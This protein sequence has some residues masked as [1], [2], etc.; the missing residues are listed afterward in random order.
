MHRHLC[1]V[2]SAFVI[3]S[4]AFSAAAE[5]RQ[6]DF[7]ETYLDNGL[8]VLT[9][10]DFST[11]IVAV[12]V[13]YHV[14]SKN[15]Q[16]DRQGFAH[17]FEHMMFRGS[18]LVPPEAHAALIRSVGGD[19]NAFTSFDF[20]GYVNTMPSNQL[21]LAL[22]LEAERMLFLTVDQEGFDTERQVVKEERRQDLNQPYGTVFER[23][24]PVIF[25]QHPYQ[26]TPIGKIAHLEAATLDELRAFWDSYYVPNNATLVMVGA[27]KHKDARKAA[28][29]YFG[30]MPSLA[31]PE[32]VMIQEPPQTEQREATLEERLGSVPLVR[33]AYRAVPASDPDYIPLQILTDILGGG[34]SSRLYQDLVKTRKMSQEAYAYIWGLEQDGML[35]VG[36]ELAQGGD[37]DTAPVLQALD[38][39]V[40]RVQNELVSGPE[41][42]KVKN[43]MLRSVVTGQLNVF[44]KARRLGESIIEQGDAEYLNK[45]L[46][47]IRAVTPEDLQRVARKHLTQ[48]Q[49][50]VVQV[51]PNPDFEYDP[52]EYSDIPVRPPLFSMHF[53]AEDAKGIPTI[54]V[55]VANPKEGDPAELILEAQSVI[56]AAFVEHAEAAPDPREG[57]WTVNI[58]LTEEG[59]ERMM[60]ATEA[61]VGRKLALVVADKI[62]AAPVVRAAISKAAQISGDFT[63]EEAKSLAEKLNTKP[64]YQKTGIQRPDDYPTEPPLHDLLEGLPEVAVKEKTLSNGLK[65][66]VVPN[67][68][69]PFTT[70]TL[71]IKYGAWAEDPAKPGVANL[72]LDMLTQGTENYTSAE[73]AETIEF[74]A[75]TLNGEAGMDVASVTATSLADKLDLAVELM[76]E[77]VLRPAFP[78]DELTIM[79]EQLKNN[80]AVQQNDPRY[81]A[82]RELNLQLF[83]EHPYGRPVTGDLEDVDAI[84]PGDLRAYW[85]TYVRPDTTV[86]YIA[87]DVKPR[88]AFKIAEEHFGD[89]EVS[90]PKPEIEAPEIPANREMQI[91]LVNI[92]GAVQSEI[93]VGQISITR[94]HPLYH[95]SR[96]FSQILGLGFESRLVREIRVKR[97]LTYGVYS[98]FQPQRFTGTFLAST[99][100]RT[101]TTAE[102]V[103]AV[104]D[105][106]NSMKTDPP[107]DAEIQMAK[108]YLVGG[109]PQDLETPQDKVQYEWL[110]EYNKL[111]KD[112]L[113]EAL[114]GYR[115]TTPEQL[116]E[117][118][119][120]VLDPSR[121]VIVVAGDAAKIQAGLEAIAP[122]TVIE[123]KQAAPEEA[124]DEAA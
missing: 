38:E 62:V 25:Q 112:Y 11:P 103:Q 30:W 94:G 13:Y 89:W 24:L 111:S 21:E 104:L 16:P 63:E 90:Q 46:D 95:P 33:F 101:E 49:R 120:D 55:P 50:T 12:Q 79:K 88:D 105:V 14:G 7:E 40:A 108:S 97:G 9:L 85:Q 68:E 124:G 99:F 32:R 3:L 2:L 65:V 84:M 75:L 59:S 67:T 87:G 119:T 80:L 48:S 35:F 34:E 122:V 74:N 15:E 47:L 45:Q 76:A 71:G 114:D 27:V 20:T 61:N 117:L 4:L 39:H 116:L 113:E 121:F 82:S 22:W 10:E 51:L 93:R 86:L 36:A 91:H 1:F 118:A 53:V 26:W 77:V 81:I 19:T 70:A 107:T 100:T 115:T 110:I 73:L 98:Y 43:Q 58:S 18:E 102:T 69:L 106:I 57:L 123:P 6:Y 109:F 56:D 52:A 5:D 41:L 96:V 29:K 8:R 28:E 44:G 92:P 37:M 72:A 83:G 66:V 17:M 23:L 64:R 60:A 54:T 31:K 78:E 42:E